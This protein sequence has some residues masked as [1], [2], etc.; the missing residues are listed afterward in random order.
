MNRQTG[1]HLAICTHNPELW[2][3]RMLDQSLAGLYPGCGWPK[4]LR[5]CWTA[6]D[7]VT[8]DVAASNMAHGTWSA[9]DVLIIQADGSKQGRE[10]EQMGCR[11]FLH[12][13]WE[14]PLY[15]FRVYDNVS[16]GI[17]PYAFHQIAGQPKNKPY[18]NTDSPTRMACLP[19]SQKD[20]VRSS[21]HRHTHQRRHRIALIAAYKPLRSELKRCIQ[22]RQWRS[23]PFGAVTD[24]RRIKSKTY[25][26]A[27]TRNTNTLRLCLL[28]QLSEALPVDLYGKGWERCEQL[29]DQRTQWLGPCGDKQTTL[30][31]YAYSLVLENCIWPGYHTEK[32]AQAIAAG[33]IPITCLDAETEKQIPHDCYIRIEYKDLSATTQ[34]LQSMCHADR[35][36]LSKAGERFLA[37]SFA[38]NYFEVDYA[39]D[40][41]DKALRF[42]EQLD[43][44]TA[45][46]QR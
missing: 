35:A 30:A 40:I 3:N 24:I 31:S 42:A 17:T 34:I 32:L 6:G 27:K 41:A 28:Q 10:L 22:E 21:K 43:T 25:R 46:R 38:K 18:I 29:A 8:G 26:Q 2:G 39:Q 11:A 23:S 13:C 1:L 36:K 20:W 37:S 5:Q 14:S 16:K 15:A 9:N 19:G 44:C 33:T 7:V 12:I 4:E 45:H